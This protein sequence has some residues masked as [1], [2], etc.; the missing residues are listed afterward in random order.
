MRQGSLFAVAFDAAKLQVSGSPVAVV[1]NVRYYSTRG[2]ADFDVSPAGT[3]IF[4]EGTGQ[5]IYRPLVLMDATGARTPIL[6][7]PQEYSNPRF[8]RDGKRIAFDTLE[9]GKRDIWAYDPQREIKTRLTLAPGE[10]TNAVWTPDGERIAYGQADGIYWVRSGGG[11]EPERLLESR[12]SPIPL[13]FSP[14][15]KR[16]TYQETPLNAAND[17]RLLEFDLQDPAHPRPGKSSPLMTTP[18][19][20]REAL[21]SPDGKWLAYE[22][23]ESGTNEV[24]VRS[25]PDPGGRWQISNR[26]GFRPRWSPS[27]KELLFTSEGKIFAVS[28][29]AEHSGFV[30]SKPRVWADFGSR[31]LGYDITL[32]GNQILVSD[33][34]TIQEG[35]ERLPTRLVFLLNFLDELKRRIP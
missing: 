25:F 3:L 10:H 35:T 23:N 14:D 19:D 20:E 7:A 32:D 16:L 21:F 33:D 17:I 18:S 30:A 31:V 12:N 29:S 26:G 22:S 13:S 34:P 27:R 15:A 6:K 9:S 2:S 4:I 28:Y 11:G 24:Y 8:S 1:P 5:T